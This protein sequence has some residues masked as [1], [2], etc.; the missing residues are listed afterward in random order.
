MLSEK[1]TRVANFAF[2]D[3]R[4]V[5]FEEDSPM[6]TYAGERLIK[7]LCNSL[8]KRGGTIEEIEDIM[9]NNGFDMK[10]RVHDVDELTMKRL[11]KGLN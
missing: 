1:E 6:T 5:C 7:D 8:F 9:K 2:R 3:I 11:K 10:I 4:K